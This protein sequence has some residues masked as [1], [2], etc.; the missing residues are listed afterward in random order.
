MRKG[1]K[2]RI[3]VCGH[4]ER[5]HCGRGMCTECYQRF[6]CK[7]EP[8]FLERRA[9]Y[10]RKYRQDQAFRI[11]EYAKKRVYNTQHREQNRESNRRRRYGL[12]AAQQKEMLAARPACEICNRLF[13]PALE[14][15]IDHDHGSGR[16]RGVLCH[17]CNLGI[18][19]LND[20]LET[21]LSAAIY[22]ERCA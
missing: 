4:P 2:P 7:T 19:C 15:C 13:G 11:K 22:L 3:N 20:S 12:T 16:V 8:E 5:K 6:R 18:G 9:E 17:T 10:Q 1:P 14:P 21:L